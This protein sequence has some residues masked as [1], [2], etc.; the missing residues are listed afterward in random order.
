MDT[1][2]LPE[3]F[4]FATLCV[5]EAAGASS[6]RWLLEDSQPDSVPACYPLERNVL[7]KV[8]IVRDCIGLPVNLRRFIE[9]IHHVDNI[10]LNL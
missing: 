8:V 10:Q 6:P 9:Q 1:C 5:Q 3:S 4:H 2:G 7:G